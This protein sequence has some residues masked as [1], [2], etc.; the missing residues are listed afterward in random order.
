V[1]VSGV[2]H[3]CCL[4]K[5]YHRQELDL[6]E[7]EEKSRIYEGSGAVVATETFSTKVMAEK[8]SVSL[9]RGRRLECCI[10]AWRAVV[11]SL[12]ARFLLSW[13]APLNHELSNLGN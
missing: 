3:Y 4:Q 13:K 12:D 11:E 8:E 5:V 7:H 9:R 2:F 10:E 6:L 1:P